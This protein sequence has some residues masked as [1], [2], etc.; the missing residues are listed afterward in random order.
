M[1]SLGLGQ[2]MIYLG[3]VNRFQGEIWSLIGRINI[4]DFQF[5]K[6][7]MAFVLS[8]DCRDCSFSKIRELMYKTWRPNFLA[9]LKALL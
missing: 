9:A 8:H 7:S 2:D 3:C 1:I 5:V 6:V 4:F